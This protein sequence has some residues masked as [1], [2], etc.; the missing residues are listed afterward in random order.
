MPEVAQQ[1]GVR[2]RMPVH[3]PKFLNPQWLSLLVSHPRPQPLSPAA[4]SDQTPCPA[5][6]SNQGCATERW[7][8]PTLLQPAVPFKN[9]PRRDYVSQKALPVR[10]VTFPAKRPLGQK[11][12]AAAAAGE[13][14]AR[15]GGA[16]GPSRG[17]SCA[18]RPGT[19]TRRGRRRA[20][21]SLFE[22]AGVRKKA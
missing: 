8:A 2:N 9:R 6:R 1:V 16:R 20:S 10:Y 17:P 3:F 18:P 11:E 12:A 15:G 13:A 7:R 22:E 21:A 5:A 4:W 19:W 14:G